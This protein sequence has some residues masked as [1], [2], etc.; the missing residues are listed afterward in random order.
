MAD[1]TDD[2]CPENDDA[3]TVA[4][5]AA[6]TRPLFPPCPS[7]CVSDYRD[8]YA[9][10]WE[11][12]DDTDEWVRS[13]ALWASEHVSVEV[14]ERHSLDGRVTFAAP[15]I[16]SESFVDGRSASLADVRAVAAD[17]WQAARKCE[18][19]VPVAEPR[20]TPDVIQAIRADPLLDEAGKAYLI[21]QYQLWLWIDGAGPDPRAAS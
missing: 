14:D 13:H 8:R 11:I 16:Y 2:A 9:H 15:W 4:R 10:D 21:D 20:L 12:L 18:E 19:L 1:R 6:V 7:W 17:L 5:Q 3:S